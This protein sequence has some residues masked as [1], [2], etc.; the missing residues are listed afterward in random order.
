VNDWRAAALSLTAVATLA[1]TGCEHQREYDSALTIVQELEAHGMCSN[2]DW[3]TDVDA[4][5]QRHGETIAATVWDRPS[6]SPRVQ[7]VGWF[8]V[9]H[10]EATALA[11]EEVIGGRVVR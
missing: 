1:L 7:G 11:V 6:G 3:V 4:I 2:A 9:T 10:R 5:C 8:V